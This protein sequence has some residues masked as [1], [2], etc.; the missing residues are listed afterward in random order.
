KCAL[1]F[2]RNA[3]DFVEQNNFSRCQG[4]ELGNELS[5]GRIDHLESDDFR[6]LQ[7]RASLEPGEFGIADG[8]QNN[9]E[10]CLADAG[11]TAN[12]Q[13][14]RIYL[15]VLLFVVSRWNLRE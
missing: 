11:N 3:V 6:R 14:T 4:S 8:S 10:K 13:V 2:Q 12:Q 5:G 9:A 7:V 1:G 15:P